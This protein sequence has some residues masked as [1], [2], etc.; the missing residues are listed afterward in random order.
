MQTL[1]LFCIIL[2]ALAFLYRFS[3]ELLDAV[4]IATYGLVRLSVKHRATLER[5][6][7][8][9][10]GLDKA[11]RKQFERRVKELLYEKDWIGKGIT[12]TWDMKVRIAG[13]MAQVSFG[14][15]DLLLLHFKRIM[16]L[17]DEYMNR[18]TG[19]RH[20]GEVAPGSG[21]IILSWANFEKG[22]ARPDDAHNVGLHEMAHALWLE[23]GIDNGEYHFLPA[24]PLQRWQELAQEEIGLMNKGKDR[25][26]RAYAGTN[27]AEYFAVAV[28]YFFERP[29]DLKTALPEVY[30]CLCD[31]LRQD[32]AAMAMA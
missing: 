6:N 19:Q 8:Y 25:F 16:I 10:G 26:L 15:D 30:G 5:R 31:L 12:L 29:G 32:P 27:Q 1:V 4:G 23:N 2:M 17:P 24:E 20:V 11:R 28:E 13:A 9:Y 21:T 18:R 7:P 14:F 3:K 22:Y